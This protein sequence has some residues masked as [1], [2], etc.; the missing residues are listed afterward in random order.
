VPNI[1]E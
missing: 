1:G